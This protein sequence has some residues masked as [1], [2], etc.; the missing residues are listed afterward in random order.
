MEIKLEETVVKSNLWLIILSKLK[1]SIEA[2]L[3]IIYHMVELRK[4]GPIGKPVEV[5]L[6]LS[7]KQIANRGIITR[8]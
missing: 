8:A 4:G 6:D 5:I 2:F 3:T 7:G 1:L